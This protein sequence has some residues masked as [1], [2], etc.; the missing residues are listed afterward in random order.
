MLNP[1]IVDYIFSSASIQRWNDYPRMVDLVELDKQAH[2]FIIAFFIAKLEKE[3]GATADS[4]EWGKMHTFTLNHPLGS[5]KILDMVFNL[6]S[7]ACL[8][9]LIG[10]PGSMIND[11]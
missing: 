3:L 10:I 6:N 4:W 5:V 2:K 8:T 7:K 11:W 9:F 1:K